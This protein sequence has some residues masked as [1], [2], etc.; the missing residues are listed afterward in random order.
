MPPKTNFSTT[1][2]Q[3]TTDYYVLVSV[4]MSTMLST[5]RVAVVKSFYFVT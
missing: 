2:S 3:M 4:V 1:K 5:G